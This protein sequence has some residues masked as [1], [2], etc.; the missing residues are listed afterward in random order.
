[1]SKGKKTGNINTGGGA[2]INGN[3]NVDG[4]G[5]FVGRDQK[6]SPGRKLKLEVI[7]PIIVALITAMGIIIVAIINYS[8]EIDKTRL[9]IQLTQTAQVITSTASF[10]PMPQ[11]TETA[12]SYQFP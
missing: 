3:V 4:R 5:T 8:T 11:I 6:S 10:T 9:K 1:M 7:V 12:T 2:H